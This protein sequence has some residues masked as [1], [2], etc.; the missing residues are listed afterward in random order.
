MVSLLEEKKWVATSLRSDNFIF[1]I[2]A[3]RVLVRANGERV[4]GDVNVQTRAKEAPS[5]S[6]RDRIF[7]VLNDFGEL[8]RNSQN[9][10][11]GPTQS[12][13]SQSW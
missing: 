11:F 2:I 3:T 8:P 13:G 10:I 6:D 12:R 5:R 9:S 1:L 4:K 7:T